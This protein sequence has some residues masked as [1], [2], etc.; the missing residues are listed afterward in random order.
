[1]FANMHVN[2]H[3][4]KMHGSNCKIGTHGTS[5]R[6][7]TYLIYFLAL[8]N[9]YRAIKYISQLSAIAAATKSTKQ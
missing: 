7:R 8:E 5:F 9:S 2:A 6:G 3:I 1:V 4:T